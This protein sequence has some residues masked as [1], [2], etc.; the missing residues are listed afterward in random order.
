MSLP[1]C[2][3]ELI[4]DFHDEHRVAEKRERLIREFKCYFYHDF[5]S[6]S[7]YRHYYGLGDF[8]L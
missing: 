6:D 7:L 1:K 5:L 2:L 4:L 3:V 8:W